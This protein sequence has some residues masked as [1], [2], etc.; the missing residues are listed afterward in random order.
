MVELTIVSVPPTWAM[1]PPPAPALLPEKVEL[2]IVFEKCRVVKTYLRKDKAR[3]QQVLEKVIADA[4][5]TITAGDCLNLVAV[6]RL[7]RL[8]S[9][10]NCYNFFTINSNFTHFRRLPDDENFHK[11]K[12]CFCF[13]HF[14]HFYY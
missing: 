2:M 13:E 12:K 5:E 7:F 6:L 10:E 14:H 1:P 4:L 9:T 3:T 11:K 8:Q